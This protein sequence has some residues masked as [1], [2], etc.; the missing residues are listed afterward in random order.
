MTVKH[1][2]R[3][4][5]S[6]KNFIFPLKLDKMLVSTRK[7][8]PTALLCMVDQKRPSFITLF[9]FVSVLMSKGAFFRSVL[10]L[11]S[12]STYC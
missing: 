12:V 1:F 7:L 8:V 5:S 11:E 3:F 4:I 6:I 9:S 2:F 10:K